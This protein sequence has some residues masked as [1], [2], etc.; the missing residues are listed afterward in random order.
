MKGR[1]DKLS[2]VQVSSKVSHKMLVGMYNKKPKI[3]ENNDMVFIKSGF[4]LF[5]GVILILIFSLCTIFMDDYVVDIMKENSINSN[6]SD[7]LYI[8]GYSLTALFILIGIKLVIMFFSHK[9]IV[10]KDAITS[11]KMFSTRTIKL[12][13][14]EAVTFSN[15]KGLVFKG[16]NTKVVFGNFTIGLIEILKFIDENIPKCKCETAIVKAKKMLRNNRINV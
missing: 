13:N 9:I 6:M 3:N 2:T 1:A 14:L 8:C 5:S 15:A 16:D 10:S 11:K 7:T 12:S 4:I